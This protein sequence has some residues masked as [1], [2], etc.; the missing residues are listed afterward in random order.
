VTAC[1]DGDAGRAAEEAADVIYHMAVALQA[2]DTSIDAVAL[3]LFARS[4]D[5]KPARARVAR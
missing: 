1:A 5:S 4:E 2:L 3:A